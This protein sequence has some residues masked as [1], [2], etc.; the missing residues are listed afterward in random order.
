MTKTATVSLQGNLYEVDAALAGCK[1]ELVFDP[2]DLSD[3]DVRHHGRPAGKAVPFRIGRHVHA[4]AVADTPPADENGLA[5]DTDLLALAST[6]GPGPDPHLQLQAELA[7]FAAL[8]PEQSADC[9]DR[10]ESR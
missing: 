4:K 7:S 9:T 5:Y 3:I 2:F 8:L 1:A 6:S 10:E